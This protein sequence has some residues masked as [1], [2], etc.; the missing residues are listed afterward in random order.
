MLPYRA[1]PIPEH[2]ADPEP[3][4]H[5]SNSLD[6][7]E[8]DPSISQIEYDFQDD[9]CAEKELIGAYTLTKLAIMQRNGS[10][11]D[12]FIRDIKTPQRFPKRTPKPMVSVEDLE[13]GFGK[14]RQ[15]WLTSTEHEQL[16]RLL[17][18]TIGPSICRKISRSIVFGVGSFSNQGMY[19]LEDRSMLQFVAWMDIISM[20]RCRLSYPC[21]QHRSLT[22]GSVANMTLTPIT[23]FAQ[24]PNFNSVD[25]QFLANHHVT[26][27]E[28]PKGYNEIDESTF[29]TSLYVPHDDI[30]IELRNGTPPLSLQPDLSELSQ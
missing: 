12:D 4:G 18:R 28:H 25:E 8:T 3:L 17:E 1:P 14:A 5:R 22:D 24:E 6:E 21:V 27:V 10:L 13:Q 20:S 30:F 19:E 11:S 15:K 2:R 29:T 16:P 26:V 23:L 9:D 7:D